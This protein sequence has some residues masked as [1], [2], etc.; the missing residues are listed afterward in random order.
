MEPYLDEGRYLFVDNW[1]TSIDLAE[2]LLDRNTHVVGT[3]RANRKRNPKKV[4]NEKL[5]RGS[6]AAKR[7]RRGIVVL[8]WKDRRYELML[9]TKHDNTMKS[10]IRRRITF[11]KPHIV[12]DFNNG[13]SNIDL[14]HQMGS[15]HTCLRRS[16]K[17]YRKLI[18]DLICNTSTVNA[19]SIYTSVTG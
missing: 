15:Y 13:R 1:Y 18:F 14:T 17:C 11:E 9:S 7:N 8:K 4:T 10:F 12:A 3:L 2:K 6:I 19:L 16:I 5:V